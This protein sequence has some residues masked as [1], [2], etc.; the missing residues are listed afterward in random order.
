M[1]SLTLVYQPLLFVFLLFPSSRIM[2]KFQFVYKLNNFINFT[3]ILP[4][5]VCDQSFSAFLLLNKYKYFPP[6]LFTLKEKLPVDN[7]THMIT[8][9]NHPHFK[10]VILR[11][12]YKYLHHTLLFFSS[13]SS[14]TVKTLFWHA[15]KFFFSYDSFL[16][17]KKSFFDYNR[18]EFNNTTLNFNKNLTLHMRLQK[19]TL[20]LFKLTSYLNTYSFLNLFLKNA[21]LSKKK[22]LIRIKP[23][24]KNT[25]KMRNTANI[26]LGGNKNAA[27]IN[28]QL[29]GLFTKTPRQIF[30]VMF[31]P[32]LFK[33]TFLY[34]SSNI[35]I[36]F[37]VS[38]IA[39][40]YF[41]SF[42][43]TN[44]LP[45]G[46]FH[47]II[48]KKVIKVFNFKKFT[49][50]HTPWQHTSL[51][52][53]IE[54]CTGSKVFIKFFFFLNFLLNDAEKIR[55]VLWYQKLKAFQKTVGAGFFLYESIEILYIG[56]K[57]KD[58]YFLL[59]WVCRTLH[60]ISFWKHRSFF[61]YLKY[62]FKYFFTEIFDEVGIKG[63]KFRLKGKISVSG[64]AR[65]RKINCII[66]Q[67]GMSTYENRILH[68]LELVK[69]FTGV[70]GLQIWLFF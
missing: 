23:Y 14:W 11:R 56:L 61:H 53:F 63:I 4:T 30:F 37:L 24:W 70:M 60:K 31:S 21:Y 59:S 55:C 41:C 10:N 25:N 36:N 32:L 8:D 29:T 22:K 39:K 52:R 46:T 19:Y 43:K 50:L 7:V 3:Q 68:S 26:H 15:R 17:D 9:S 69:T 47:Q 18:F 54:Y 66:G 16:I 35:S 12:L 2:H 48:K 1:F 44:L 62:V 58:P 64:N 40:F 34:K 51:I 13:L 65:T 5:I 67:T 27:S 38:L 33:H 57:I 49:L 6:R 20:R 28:S 45:S 42:N